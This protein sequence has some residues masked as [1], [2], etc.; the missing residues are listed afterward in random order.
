MACWVEPYVGQMGPQFHETRSEVIRFD[1][2]AA[3]TFEMPI[4]V[5]NLL[6]FFTNSVLQL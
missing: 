2:T 6:P 4:L 5:P 3:K 1:S